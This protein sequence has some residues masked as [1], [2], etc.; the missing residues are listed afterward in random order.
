EKSSIESAFHQ[1]NCSQHQ[2]SRCTCDGK[3]QYLPRL[4]NQLGCMKGQ[5][6]GI[7][8][9]T[10]RTMSPH[11]CKNNSAMRSMLQ[12]QPPASRLLQTSGVIESNISSEK[13]PKQA[14]IQVQQ[15]QKPI[16]CPGQC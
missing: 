11:L 14:G 13:Y 16:L 7:E 10:F 12:C 8:S 3:V 2:T 9:M 4:G 5:F 1:P 6:R 15:E